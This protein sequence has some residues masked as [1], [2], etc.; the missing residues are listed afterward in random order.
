MQAAGLD[1]RAEEL[2]AEMVREG[3]GEAAA[4]VYETEIAKALGPEGSVAG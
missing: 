2:R 3:R 4:E 1:D